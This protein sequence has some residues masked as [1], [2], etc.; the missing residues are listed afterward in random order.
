MDAIWWIATAA[1]AATLTSGIVY[2][3]M[4]SR[5]QVELSKQREKNWLGRATLSAQK[6]AIEG[7]LKSAQETTRR[8]A[9]DEFLADIRVEERHYTREHRVLFLTRRMLV[10]Q[11][12][13]FFRNIP[14]SQW[15]ENEMPIEE[16]AD[17]EKLAQ[18][19][20]VFTPEML[21]GPP[22]FKLLH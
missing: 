7:S 8:Q 17:V 16:G 22:G 20:A 13:I 3:I 12:R 2:L 15:V 21:A 10:R 14:L 6:E 1:A 11:E 4:H 5:M 9:M 19:M 18:A